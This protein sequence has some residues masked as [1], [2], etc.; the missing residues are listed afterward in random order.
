MARLAG[1]LMESDRDELLSVITLKCIKSALSTRSPT[2]ESPSSF[3]PTQCGFPSSQNAQATS[4]NAGKAVAVAVKVEEVEVE[5]GNLQVLVQKVAQAVPR[6]PQVLEPVLAQ[7]GVQ[8]RP[9]VLVGAVVEVQ[10]RFQTGEA[11]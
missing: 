8:A 10:P 4:S 5:V 6:V 9:L 2:L 3:L 11:E 1:I 7:A